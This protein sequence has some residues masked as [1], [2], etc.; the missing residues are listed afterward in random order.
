[1][2]HEFKKG[3]LVLIYDTI[4]A[5]VLSNSCSSSVSVHIMY[6]SGSSI[7][8]YTSKNLVKS[9]AYKHYIKRIINKY[10]D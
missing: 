6:L 8:N 10:K 4:S 3:E 2:P 9:Y 7:P 5:L 1:M